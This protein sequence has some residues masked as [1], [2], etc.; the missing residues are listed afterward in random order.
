VCRRCLPQTVARHSLARCAYYV[1]AVVKL[2][3]N[4]VTITHYALHCTSS[5]RSARSGLEVVFTP[6][7]R[8]AAQSHFH[9]YLDGHGDSNS[10]ATGG[11]RPCP[12]G[13]CFSALA[14]LSRA[15]IGKNHTK[16]HG[17]NTSGTGGGLREVG[18]S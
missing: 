4:E 18:D 9:D 17:S 5:R 2:P 16:Q 10:C 8:H 7:A 12:R 13:R 11:G 6:V 1:G 3:L 15:Q 14:I